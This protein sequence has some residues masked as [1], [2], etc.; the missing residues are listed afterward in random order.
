MLFVA[1][2]FFSCCE[3]GVVFVSRSSLSFA[4]E[5]TNEVIQ[6]SILFPQQ[7]SF[8]YFPELGQYPSSVSFSDQQFEQTLAHRRARKSSL[9]DIYRKYSSETPFFRTNDGKK[10]LF[11]AGLANVMHVFIFVFLEKYN[12]LPSKLFTIVL[13]RSR[14]LSM[15]KHRSL[16]SIIL[17][18]AGTRKMSSCQRNC[19]QIPLPNSTCMRRVSSAKVL[20]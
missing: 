16:S 17:A 9:Y 6:H 14:T 5:S 2:F 18:K 3:K 11:L 1:N 19:S 10:N 8:Y 20:K 7:N 13:W 4:R 12:F 15:L